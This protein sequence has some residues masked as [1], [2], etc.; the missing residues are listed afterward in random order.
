MRLK[1]KR[2]STAAKAAP[3]AGAGAAGLA[4]TAAWRFVRRRRGTA[5]GLGEDAPAAKRDWTCECGQQFRVA[6]EDRH[7]VFWLADA[8]DGDP[9]LGDQCP[10][11]EKPL[12]TQEA[13]A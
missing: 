2:K 5:D 8:E 7:R 6:G 9:V 13:A 11:C 4:A 12:S 10:N 1:R 3:A